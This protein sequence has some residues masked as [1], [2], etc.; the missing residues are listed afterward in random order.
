MAEGLELDGL[1]GLVQSKP[2]NDYY[3]MNLSLL[4]TKEIL[5]GFNSLLENPYLLRSE[6]HHVSGKEKAG[7]PL[8]RRE[9]DGAGLAQP[10]EEKAPERPHCV[11]PVLKGRL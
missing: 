11:Q 5:A 9:A 8:L 6:N 7:A 10:G 2:S 4:S 3:S 1:Y